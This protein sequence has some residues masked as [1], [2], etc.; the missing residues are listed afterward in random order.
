[1][2][3]PPRWTTSNFPF[4]KVRTS[5]GD[6]NRFKITSVITNSSAQAF[7]SGAEAQLR[8]GLYVGAKAP[9]PKVT[10]TAVA[11]V[12]VGFVEPVFARRVEDVEVDGVFDCPGFVGHV[13]GDAQDF[14][15]AHDDF[16]AIDGKL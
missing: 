7:S 2:V 10:L 14:S 11:E 9:T 3:M 16:F 6:S 15:G 12:V 13:R 5:S 1:M 8:A 4:S